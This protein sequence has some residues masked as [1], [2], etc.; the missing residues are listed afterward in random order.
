MRNLYLSRAVLACF[1]GEGGDAAAGDAGGCGCRSRPARVRARLPARG[2]GGCGRV[3]GGGAGDGSLQPGGCS[4]GC[5]PTTGAS[6]SRQLQR[7]EK[8]LEEMAASKNLTIQERE[9]LAQQLE[10]MRKETRTKEAAVGSRE[11]A[12]GG[13]VPEAS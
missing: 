2:C 7:V 8:T 10:D 5:L 12:T 1:E 4:T 3:P 11:E 13:A 9:Q 6:I